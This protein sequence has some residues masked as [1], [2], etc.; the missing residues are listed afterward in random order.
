MWGWGDCTHQEDEVWRVRDS[1]RAGGRA[2]GWLERS[3]QQSAVGSGEA[4][5]HREWGVHGA[6]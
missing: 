3:S 2:V 5:D 1:R 6:E 4:A